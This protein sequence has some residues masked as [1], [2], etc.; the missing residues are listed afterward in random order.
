MS[1]PAENTAFD[2]DTLTGD[3]RDFLLSQM[4]YMAKPWAQM[5]EAEQRAKIAITEKHAEFVVKKAVKVIAARDFERVGVRVG[6]FTVKD[7]SIKAEFTCD[8]SHAN[9][10]SISDAD[11]A[12]LVLADPEDFYGERAAAVADPDE[13]DLP[14]DDD[15]IDPDD[16]PDDGDDEGGEAMPEIPPDFDRRP[17][18]APAPAG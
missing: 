7:G 6:K 2:T 1:D 11:S 18:P 13:P 17:A 8:A 12:V 16:D 9:L 10:L 14:M 4:R 3:V 15:E 5:S